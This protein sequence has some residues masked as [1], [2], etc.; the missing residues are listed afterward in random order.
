MNGM[1]GLTPDQWLM[2]LFAYIFAMVGFVIFSKLRGRG[3]LKCLILKPSKFYSVEEHKPHGNKLN[4]P[5]WP[6]HP[7]FDTSDIYTE[8]KSAWRFWR[9]P[10]QMLVIPE[11]ARKALKWGTHM[12]GSILTEKEHKQIIAAEVAR[13]RMKQ[14]IISPMW[15][16]VIVGM[17]GMLIVLTYLGFHNI[18]AI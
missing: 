14:H 1:W 16:M 17:L 9:L 15:A 6:T 18:G 2:L 13:A 8:E 7:E 5:S 11:K 3:K 12:L 10:N 4:F